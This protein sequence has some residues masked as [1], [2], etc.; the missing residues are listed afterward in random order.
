[1]TYISRSSNDG[2]TSYFGIM[3]QWDVT[4]DLKVKVTVTYI[5]WS[6]GFAL[7]LEDCLI[8]E[9]HSLGL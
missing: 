9:C 2:R 7:Y 5:S 1:M 4:I 6:S 8:D 3:D